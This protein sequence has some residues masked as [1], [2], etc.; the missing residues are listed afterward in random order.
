MADVYQVLGIWLLTCLLVMPPGSGHS[1]SVPTHK[2][3]RWFLDCQGQG[4]EQFLVCSIVNDLALGESCPNYIVYYINSTSRV[5]FT[6]NGSSVGLVCPSITLRI[7]GGYMLN[8]ML[9]FSKQFIEGRGTL[10]A[11][12]FRVCSW[13]WRGHLNSLLS[14]K[15]NRMT[16]L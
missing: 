16:Y 2:R 4:R 6:S 10:S 13:K 9:V 5:P 14:T 3:G 11:E 8:I 1:L 12:W 7:S 15:N